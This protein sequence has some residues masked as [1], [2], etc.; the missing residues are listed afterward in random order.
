[1][2]EECQANRMQAMCN[3]NMLKRAHWNLVIKSSDNYNRNLRTTILNMFR[4]VFQPWQKRRTLH[5]PQK[6][7]TIAPD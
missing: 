7:K 4:I 5:I 6:Y 2:T 3:E 1:M